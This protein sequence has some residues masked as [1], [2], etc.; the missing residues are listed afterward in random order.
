MLINH[1]IAH[2]YYLQFLVLVEGYYPRV[3]HYSGRKSAITGHHKTIFF[4]Q[5]SFLKIMGIILL[6]KL[7]KIFSFGEDRALTTRYI[8]NKKYNDN[9]D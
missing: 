9:S 1:I 7:D 4:S 3:L 8:S 6:F 2:L 5:A